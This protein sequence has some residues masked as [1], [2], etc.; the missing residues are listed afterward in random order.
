[1]KRKKPTYERPHHQLHQIRHTSLDKLISSANLIAK[2]AIYPSKR[3]DETFHH[4]ARELM[5][6]NGLWFEMI[7][8]ARLDGH[9]LPNVVHSTELISVIHDAPMVML[10]IVEVRELLS[11]SP[12]WS[13]VAAHFHE[14]RRLWPPLGE[15][16]LL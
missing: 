10:A 6:N 7:G 9:D 14:T 8:T 11:K 5:S 2:I 15:Q 4:R 13:L 16:P 12:K 3:S 1:L